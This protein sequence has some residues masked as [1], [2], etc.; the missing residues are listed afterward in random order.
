MSAIG[1]KADIGTYRQDIPSLLAEIRL[2]IDLMVS[3]TADTGQ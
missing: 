1:D 3:T 2:S